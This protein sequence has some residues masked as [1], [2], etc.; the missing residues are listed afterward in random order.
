MEQK[1]INKRLLKVSL[2]TMITAVAFENL[3]ATADL[4]AIG[5]HFHT[6]KSLALILSF[7]LVAEIVGVVALSELSKVRGPKLAVLV[8]STLFQVGIVLVSL[9][10]NITFLILMRGIQGLG[11]G[12]FGSV[13]YVII[14]DYFDTTERPKIFFAFSLAW[15]VPSLISP[16][17]SG[18]LAQN[19]G[20]Q[21][22]F[23][24]VLP[25]SLIATLV[26]ALA[27][28]KR[29][30]IKPR[31]LESNPLLRIVYATI[32]AASILAILLALDSIPRIT[33]LLIIIP[34]IV[35]AG[36]AGKRLLPKVAFSQFPAL[37]RII[38]LRVL[39]NFA[40]FGID[41]FLPLA[42]FRDRGYS[43]A[44]AGSTLTLASLSWSAGSYLHSRFTKP[45]HRG[46]LFRR[47][48]AI[49][50]IGVA[51]TGISLYFQG[52]GSWFILAGWTIAGLG[53][54]ISYVSLSVALLDVAPRDHLDE[55]S[56]ALALAD[57]T[58]VSVGTGVAGGLIATALAIHGSRSI[59][60]G[61][62]FD[63]IACLLIFVI[64]LSIGKS[65][66]HSASQ[67]TSLA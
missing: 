42:L 66:D 47:G 26:L 43:L 13:G 9:S 41:G 45:N 58:G 21:F 4:G 37:R 17:I 29:S 40:F 38:L 50:L 16:G 3:A 61:L 34:G 67:P 46:T 48:I 56:S 57:T 63:A 27:L 64:S 25:I 8:G 23:L 7:F 11:G 44:L 20:W 35:F 24:V 33:P 53:M 28:P 14:N 36:I 31:V 10:P 22:P 49:A 12:A 1:N 2:I 32:F 19:F 18:Y 52:I 51:M 65:I 39:T 54:G 15:V 6:T 5:V 60:H 30:K 62:A 55:S 59:S